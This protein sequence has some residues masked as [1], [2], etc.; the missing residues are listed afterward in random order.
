VKEIK[1]NK[2]VGVVAHVDAG[3]TTL[4]EQLLYNTNAIK[5]PGR[6]DNKNT[7]LDYHTI[8]RDRGITVYSDQITVKYGDSKFHFID[9]P[10]HVDF[11]S[12]MERTVRILDCA[13]IILSAV[14]GIEGHTLTVWKM[15]R[16]YKVPTIFFINKMDRIGSNFQI[17]VEEIK[18][19]MTDD[20]C[21]FTEPGETGNNESGNSGI[22]S[23]IKDNGFNDS[24]IEFLADRNDELMESFLE[25]QELDYMKMLETAVT[26]IKNGEMYPCLCGSGL[27]NS[28]VDILLDILENFI[29][30]DYNPSSKF[31]GTVYKV[32]Y[33]NDGK[34]ETYIKVLAGSIRVKD[35]IKHNIVDE[36]VEKINSIW[37]GIGRK[38]IQKDCL[39]AG[40]IGS[41]SGLDLS[42]TGEGI[43]DEVDFNDLALI[44]A[45]KSKV[46]YDEKLNPREILKIFKILTEEDPTMDALWMEDLSEI[47]INVMGV[48]QLEVLKHVVM[49]RFSV[50]VNFSKPEVLYLETILDEVIGFGHFEPYKHFSEVELMISSNERG[51]GITF[52]SECSVDTLDLRWQRNIEKNI[53]EGCKKGILTGSKLTDVNI[54]LISGKAHEKHTSG[55][56]FRQ[57]TF[58]AIRHGLEQGE[59]VLLEP[60]YDFSIRVEKELSGRV[61]TDMINMKGIVEPPLYEGEFSVIAG[62]VPVSTSMDYPVELASFSGGKGIVSMVFKGYGRCW[63]QDEVVEKMKYDNDSDQEYTAYSVY[64]SKGKVYTM[65]GRRG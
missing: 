31:R 42:Y 29:K 7:V 23:H 49:E 30:T 17:V 20:M 10:G 43:G 60:F 44:P 24:I 4:L 59:C 46:V 14:E 22:I 19:T 2:T 45:L 55:G 35:S 28:G 11:S 62:K 33:D 41:I 39:E 18:K 15:L 13:V 63:N 16:K 6:V 64:C 5:E 38:R 61:M 3:K 21:V 27:K 54:T 9:T 48:I 25:E 51:S 12:E 40:E 37:V 1:M 36:S 52:S 65:K 53:E 32:R 34:K 58:R 26:L 47:H 57:A 8:E 56:D 50:V